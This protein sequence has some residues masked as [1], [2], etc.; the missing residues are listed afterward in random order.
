[1]K[2]LLIIPLLGAALIPSAAQANPNTALQPANVYFGKV[3]SGQH[4][5]AIITL[6]NPTSRNQYIRR[7][8]LAGAGGNK[9]R[10]TW[11]GVTCHTMLNLLPGDS[12]TLRVRVAT[13]RP[14]FWQTTLMVVYG[15]R[16][17]ARPARGQFNGS[18]YAHVIAPPVLANGTLN[19][20]T[21]DCQAR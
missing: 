9:F 11:G 10:L 20:P 19:C 8:S 13:E 14:E 16:I 5:T 21:Q 2:K 15:P 17:M 12:C 18:V 4:P 7:F 6:R 3:Q 1:M